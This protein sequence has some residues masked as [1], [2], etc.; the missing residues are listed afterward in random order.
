MLCDGRKVRKRNE[1]HGKTYKD[2]V[3]ALEPRYPSGGSW[4]RSHFDE[5][6]DLPGRVAPPKVLIAMTLIP[7][8]YV[9]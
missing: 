1:N 6:S 9:G 5:M 2:C 7:S 4:A 3:D 8:Y